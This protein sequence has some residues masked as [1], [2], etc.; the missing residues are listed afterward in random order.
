MDTLA[1]TGADMLIQHAIPW[2]GK[3]AV[4][5]GRYYGSEALRN[6]KLQ[7][8]AIDYAIS[9]ATPFIQNTGADMLDKLSTK[10]RPKRRYKTDR[11]ELDGGNLDT[12]LE[13]FGTPG[14]V[15]SKSMDVVGT[16]IPSTKEVFD[17]YKSGDIAKSAFSTDT[18]I[19]SSQFWSGK[20]G[21]KTLEKYKNYPCE[22][23]VK[24]G[25]KFHNTPKCSSYDAIGWHPPNWDEYEKGIKGRPK[26]GGSI[27]I[28]K[29]IGKLPKPKA[30]W[31]LP[32]HKYT[33]PY[34]DLENQ[35]KYNPKTGQILEIYDK[36][37]GKTDAIAMQHDVDYSVCKDDKKCKLKAD[38]KMVKSLDAVPY[39]ER[40]WGHWLARNTINTKQ[41]L[42]LGV[43]KNVKSRRVKR[44][45]GKKN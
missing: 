23:M 9:K 24:I 33:G 4:E 3:K 40:Q 14:K 32:G 13:Q 19:L 41:K 35:V 25:S 45:T 27:D 6:P 26:S 5:M 8:K 29:M 22:S 10:V 37:T 31:V 2:M 12:I 21:K 7:K 16:L 34:N 1:S 38:K 42:G 17:R 44:K 15:A 30:G 39:S 11:K 36:P 28:H 18:G 43:P 20:A